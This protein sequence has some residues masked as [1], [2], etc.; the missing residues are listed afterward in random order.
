[1]GSRTIGRSTGETI[2]ENRTIDQEPAEVVARRVIFDGAAASVIVSAKPNNLA[3][4][5]K[6]DYAG[7]LK[8]WV[9]SS[10]VVGGV[11]LTHLHLPSK[12][13]RGNNKTGSHYWC[14]P[15]V[16]WK[17]YADGRE[18]IYLDLFPIEST[19]GVHVTHEL[20]LYQEPGAF[21]TDLEHFFVCPGNEVMGAIGF[22]E[23]RRRPD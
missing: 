3:N 7:G 19:E 17:K 20:K 13:T 14:N 18:F 1:M 9:W 23:P 8:Y 15:V 12:N 2:T 6:S 16:M 10:G 11:I 21:P 5:C 4:W 22:K